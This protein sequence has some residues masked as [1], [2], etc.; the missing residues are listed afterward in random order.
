MARY[1]PLIILGVLLNA[2]A[3]LALKQGMHHVGHF[4]FRLENAWGVFLAVAAS[5]F[6]LAGLICYVVSVVVWLLVLSRVE[7]SFAYPLLS[8]GYIVVTLVGWL[9]LNEAVGPTRWAGILVICLG[10]WLITRTG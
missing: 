2:A 5:P 3:Q 7:V 8:I 10:V 6:V 4:E 1:L 9:L